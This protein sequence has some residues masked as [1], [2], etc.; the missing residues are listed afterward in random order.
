MSSLGENLSALGDAMRGP[1]YEIFARFSLAECLK[2]GNTTIVEI[3]MVSNLGAD[4]AVKIID[5]LGIRAT[6]SP[7]VAD[8]VWDRSQAADLRTRWIGLETGLK[9]LDEAER[10]AKTYASAC[11]GRL[12]PAIYGDTIDKCSADL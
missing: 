1:D 3:S 5:E 7:I 6:E 12:I 2:S 4:K 11:E 9:K 8:G 10:F